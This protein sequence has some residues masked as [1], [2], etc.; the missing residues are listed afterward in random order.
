MR[1][2]GVLNRR[3]LD[4]FGQLEFARA[5]RYKFPLAIALFDL[6]NFKAVN[7]Q[8]GHAEG[9][10]AL[11]LFASAVQAGIRE[12][13]IVGRLGGDE[14]VMLMPHTDPQGALT[15]VQRLR[16]SAETLTRERITD[17]S[18]MPGV[19]AGFA[20]FPDDEVK[21]YEELL[22]RADQALY[23]AKRHR[24]MPKVDKV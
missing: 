13:D 15:T 3:A 6:D 20:A 10:R 1:L 14:F 18:P 16:E 24:K 5:Q 23:R 22:A 2:T 21:T 9:D 19:S 7:D 4:R 17:L 11:Q 12:M 8:L